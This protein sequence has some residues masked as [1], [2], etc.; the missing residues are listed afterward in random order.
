[1]RLTSAG[2]AT[3]HQCASIQSEAFLLFEN[4]KKPHH[5]ISLQQTTTDYYHG[6]L[7]LL[8]IAIKTFT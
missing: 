7:Y 6:E 8:A 5:T 3:S 4:I 1:M 2:K